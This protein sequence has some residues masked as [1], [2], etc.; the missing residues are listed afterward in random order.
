MVHELG[1]ALGFLHEQSRSDRDEHV[2]IQFQ[3]IRSGMEGNFRKSSTRNLAPYDLSSV[4]HYGRDVSTC[5]L[6][7]YFVVDEL[8][9]A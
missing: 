1:H 4:M 7:V 6:E 5:N 2:V 9:D 3:N 8:G